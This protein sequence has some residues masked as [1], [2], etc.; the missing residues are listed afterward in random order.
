MSLSDGF[1]CWVTINF[2]I[3]AV[4]AGC[5]REWHYCMYYASATTLQVAVIW[6]KLTACRES[7]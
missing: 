7:Q 3:A 2:V 4:I 1:L 5:Y 6:M